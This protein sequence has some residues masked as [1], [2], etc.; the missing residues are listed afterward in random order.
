MRQFLTQFLTSVVSGLMDKIKGAVFA[1]SF[2]VFFF[3][4][5]GVLLFAL[6]CSIAVVSLF[7]TFKGVGV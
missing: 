2:S 3:R 4:P 6:L 5:P 1:L 7:R